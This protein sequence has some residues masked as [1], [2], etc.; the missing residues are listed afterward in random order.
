VFSGK[1]LW[2]GALP[3]TAMR[4]LE[5]QL[6][7]LGNALWRA[8]GLIAKWSDP[9]LLGVA[10]RFLKADLDKEDIKDVSIVSI[11]AWAYTI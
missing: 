10:V 1:E 3:E 9:M 7:R 11:D 8:T 4:L 6:T 5:E 2:Q